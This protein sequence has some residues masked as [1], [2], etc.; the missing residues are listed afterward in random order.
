[1]PEAT[2]WQASSLLP[3]PATYPGHS[4]EFLGFG[5]IS[6]GPV[7]Y[8]E[9]FFCEWRTH[10]AVFLS[11]GGPLELAEAW[12]GRVV[13]FWPPDAAL[14][15]AEEFRGRL[16]MRCL[17]LGRPGAG[18]FDA[19]VVAS[20]LSTVARDGKVLAAV[21]TDAGLRGYSS[22]RFGRDRSGGPNCEI[23]ER[24]ARVLPRRNQQVRTGP[25]DQPPKATPT[26]R[27]SRPRERLEGDMIYRGS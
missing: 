4:C 15:S 23:G 12:L 22:H 21:A 6:R 16:G 27:T 10:F 9:R 26:V 11:R 1:M 17:P 3:F 20:F 8:H 2:N 7:F 13:F 19:A 25:T 14:E 5:L 24:G 18:L